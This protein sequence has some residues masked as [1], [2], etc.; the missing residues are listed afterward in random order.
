MNYKTVCNKTDVLTILIINSFVYKSFT[1]V[2]PVCTLTVVFKYNALCLFY[3]HA[4]HF[5]EC[6]RRGI[7]LVGRIQT[8]ALAVHWH[9]EHKFTSLHF[10]LLYCP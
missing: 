2:C 5:A 3:H 6:T 4:C 7:P 9:P 8:S 1:Y 10:T